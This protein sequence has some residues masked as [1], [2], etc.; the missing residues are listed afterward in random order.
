MADFQIGD[1][2]RLVAAHSVADSAD[3]GRLLTVRAIGPLGVRVDDGFP[4]DPDGRT[5]GWRLAMWAPA[6]VLEPAPDATAQH[7][8][9]KRD[10]ADERQPPVPDPRPSALRVSLTPADLARMEALGFVPGSGNPVGW[11]IGR[12]EQD[13]AVLADYRDEHER[14][15]AA[16]PGDATGDLAEAIGRLYPGLRAEIARLRALVPGVWTEWDRPDRGAYDGSFRKYDMIESQTA[17]EVFHH[18]D[19]WMFNIYTPSGVC[20]RGWTWDDR[21]STREEAEAACEQ[22]ARTLGVL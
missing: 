13:A 17:L 16:L 2:V 6:S 9:E 21:R 22:A 11:L 20:I 7:F 14:A 4:N 15:W 1:M 18:L 10:E 5:N 12:A 19:H 8:F 3:I